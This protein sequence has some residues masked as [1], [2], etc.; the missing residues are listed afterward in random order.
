MI[1]ELWD[2]ALPVKPRCVELRSLISS[3]AVSLLGDPGGGV[4][5]GK[6]ALVEVVGRPRRDLLDEGLPPLAS[7]AE[8]IVVPEGIQYVGAAWFGFEPVN[9]LWVIET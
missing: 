5:A 7:D 4:L 3:G 1:T 9:E 2:R 8:I 6:G